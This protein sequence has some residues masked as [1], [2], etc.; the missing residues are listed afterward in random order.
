MTEEAAVS[1]GATVFSELFIFTTAAAILAFE[2][3][4]KAQDDEA[5]KIKKDAATQKEKNDIENRFQTMELE[6]Q[7]VSNALRETQKSLD[8]LQQMQNK[9]KGWL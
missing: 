6:L 3:H 7:S 2:L 4:K 9:K 1:I 8:Q 5:A